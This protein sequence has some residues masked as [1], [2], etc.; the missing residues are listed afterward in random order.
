MKIRVEQLHYA[1]NQGTPLEFKALEEVSF[2]VAHGGFLGI[3]GG[4]GSGKTT[5]IKALNGL[6]YPTMGRVLINGTDTKSFG[7]GLARKVGVVFQRPE[8]QLFEDTVFNDVSFVLR[9]F[10]G[11]SQKEIRE[12]ARL[13]LLQVG[14][15]LDELG[16]R[17]PRS[18]SD[19]EKRK[20]AISGIL[21]N[22]PEIL[23]LDEPMVGLDPP[24]VVDLIE[25]LEQMKTTG[26]KTIV[27]VSHDMGAF[28][29]LLDQ[30]VALNHGRMAAFGSPED[31]CRCLR[32]DP[33]MIEMLPEIAV[34]VYDLR[35]AGCSI[36]P[37]EFRIPI[38][39]RELAKLAGVVSS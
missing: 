10:S 9:R 33:K 8:R 15:N 3:L 6:L 22:E 16:D 7:P 19:G 37:N 30:I 2:T 25:V 13:A 17:S 34:L 20:V 27:V 31:V 32:E 28:L 39:A 1:Y 21:L 29:P 18:L 12:K 24:S 35:S 26:E 23:V 36:P 4:T 14:L 5:L 11:R 38:L